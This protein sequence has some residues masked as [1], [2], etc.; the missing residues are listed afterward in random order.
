MN[1]TSLVLTEGAAVTGEFEGAAMGDVVGT[2]VG[3]F[4]GAA[5]G[6]VVAVEVGLAVT[7]CAVGKLL[8]FAVVG[9]AVGDSVLGFVD[10]L[11]VVGRRVG[12]RVGRVVRLFVGRRVGLDVVGFR[13][14][15]CRA[16][17]ICGSF[18]SLLPVAVFTRNETEAR[19]KRLSAKQPNLVRIMLLE[20]ELALV[21]INNN[22][23]SLTVQS[24][25]IPFS[26]VQFVNE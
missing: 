3:D 10:G 11:R 23:E 6:V 7:G 25:S 5:V 26:A 17:W 12:F 15:T 16:R 4:V 22:M 1:I 18:A 20:L 24:T 14:D 2:A 13:V 21:L 19:K 9:F 8:G